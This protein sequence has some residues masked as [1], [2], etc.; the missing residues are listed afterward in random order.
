MVSQ[1]VLVGHSMYSSGAAS[2]ENRQVVD[3]I[4]LLRESGYRVVAWLPSVRGFDFPEKI[5]ASARILFGPRALR[6]IS[7]MAADGQID[8]IHAHNIFP[9]LSPA[10]LTAGRGHCAVVMTLHNY[11]LMCL[12]G[13][14][15][16]DGRTCELC[17]NRVP[18]RGVVYRCYRNSLASSASLATAI[19][20]HR[21]LGT[22]NNHVSL[23]LPVSEFV[24]GKHIEGGLAPERMHTKPNF[25]WPIPTRSDSGRHFAYVGRLSREKGVGTLIDVWKRSYGELVVVGDGPDAKSLRIRA[26]SAV[27]FVGILDPRRVETVLA[28]SRALL[29]P[30]ITYE[31][32]PRTVLEAYAAGVPVLGSA[33]GGLGELIQH[34]F[35]GLQVEPENPAAWTEAIE[36]LL[37]DGESVRLGEGA[38]R[39][40]KEKYTP[41]RGLKNLKA[42]YRKASE[43]SGHERT[44]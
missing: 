33:T 8:V 1:T 37:D 19:S 20:L 24:R 18:W 5:R 16:R 42:A 39:L 10:I 41:E 4:R 22:F 31:G 21:A 34:D 43:I 36:R 32:A 38:F 27:R 23:F 12:P 25:V 44:D 29:V 30:S 7:K 17:L 11:R 35:S 3:E 2:G 15:V 13:T 28:K 14:F 6:A 40:W 9:M 26:S